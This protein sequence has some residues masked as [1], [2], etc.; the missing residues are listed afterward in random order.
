ML[1]FN[2]AMPFNLNLQK[3]VMIQYIFSNYMTKFG[4]IYKTLHFQL[5]S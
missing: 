2:G 4:H 3:W 5:N 1:N